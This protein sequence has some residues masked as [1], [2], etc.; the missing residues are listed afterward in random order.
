MT[1]SK[2]TIETDADLD[3]LKRLLSLAGVEQPKESPLPEKPPGAF[4]AVDDSEMN[5][6]GW[7]DT[8]AIR[9]DAE[10]FEGGDADGMIDLETDDA[11]NLHAEFEDEIDETKDPMYDYGYRTE[12]GTGIKIDN[13]TNQRHI[14]K[15]PK[16][17]QNVGSARY[18][19][20]PLSSEDTEHL[21][22]DINETE[23]ENMLLQDFDA[24]MDI[25]QLMRSYGMREQEVR[26]IL[27]KHGHQGYDVGAEHGMKNPNHPMHSD[28]DLYM[29]NDELPMDMSH[30]AYEEMESDEDIIGRVDESSYRKLDE[31]ST[32]TGVDEMSLFSALHKVRTGMIQSINE[33]ET[34]S[35]AAAFINLLETE[36][37]TRLCAVHTVFRSLKEKNLLEAYKQHINGVDLDVSE[38]IKEHG[39]GPEKV[40]ASKRWAFNVGKKVHFLDGYYKE[41][42]QEIFEHA[43][44]IKYRGVIKLRA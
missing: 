9:Q 14:Y 35:L 17:S 8:D 16:L 23:V 29:E 24:G 34:T 39:Y 26:R 20:E 22:E 33:A 28:D 27:T 11:G 12:P 30:P 40:L 44:S 13:A 41:V 2:I 31:I 21:A 36:D 15:D 37:T 3:G 32:L 1:W 4:Q 6:E 19:S 18:A 5:A 7:L 38:F 25:T 42:K 43:D 10:E